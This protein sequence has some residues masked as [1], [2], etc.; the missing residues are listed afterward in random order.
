MTSQGPIQSPGLNL[1][2]LY[3]AAKT[4]SGQETGLSGL[5]ANDMIGPDVKNRMDSAVNHVPN[6]GGRKTGSATARHRTV[7]KATTDMNRLRV[8]LL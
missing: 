7:K 2:Q 5:N 4:R 3:G 8:P 1:P 6:P